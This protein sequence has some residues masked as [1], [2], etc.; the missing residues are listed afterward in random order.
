VQYRDADYGFSLTAPADWIFFRPDVK[1]AK[2]ASRVVVLDPNAVATTVVNVGSRKV[3][4]PNAEQ[5]LRE[6]AEKEILQN[7]DYKI[8]KTF[9]LRD[10]TW[11]ERT[12]AGHPALSVLGDVEEG[13]DKKVGCAV[14]VRGKTNAAVFT[15]TA[16]A[17]EFDACAPDFDAL[18]NS[19]REQ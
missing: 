2:D 1:E 16:P 13:K 7:E 18:V 9:K 19:Y 3:H 10:D 12:V 8:V 6:W 5:P 11:K 17:K 4:A 14:F 15:M